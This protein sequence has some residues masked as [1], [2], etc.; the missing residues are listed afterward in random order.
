MVGGEDCVCEWG[1]MEGVV[2]CG[3]RGVGEDLYI[4]G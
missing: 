4:W 3:G 2:L 1:V